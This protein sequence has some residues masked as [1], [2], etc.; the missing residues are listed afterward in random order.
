MGND[1]VRSTREVVEDHLRLA[2]V[3]SVEED[4]KRNYDPGVACFIDGK[5]HHGHAALKRLADRLSR[6]LPGAEFRYNSVLSHADVAFLEWEATSDEVQVRDGADTFVVR[7]GLICAQT[8]HY[9]V[10]PRAGDQRG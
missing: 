6:E 1:E 4:A 3:G 9:T 8:I 5:I 10:E 7:D 2:K